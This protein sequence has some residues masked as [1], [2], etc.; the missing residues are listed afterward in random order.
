ML[1]QVRW[2][3]VCAK[4]NSLNLQDGGISEKYALMCVGMHDRSYV[5]YCT[6]VVNKN[7]E[8]E[9]KHFQ[10]GPTSQTQRV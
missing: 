3:C 1:T 9:A 7:M 4:R 6:H 5:L 8:L 10:Q 2:V